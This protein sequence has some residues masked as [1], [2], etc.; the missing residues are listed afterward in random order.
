LQEFGVLSIAGGDRFE[1]GC[2]ITQRLPGAHKP[3]GEPGFADARV[4]SGDEESGHE[5]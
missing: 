3:A 2:V 4:G 1:R 5:S